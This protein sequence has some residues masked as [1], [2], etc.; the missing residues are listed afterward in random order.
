MGYGME[1]VAQ[2][3]TLMPPADDPDAPPPLTDAERDERERLM[4][5]GFV[6]WNKRDFLNFIRGCDMRARLPHPQGL[7]NHLWTD[8]CPI[9]WC[10]LS[11]INGWHALLHTTAKSSRVSHPSVHQHPC[12]FSSVVRRSSFRLLSHVDG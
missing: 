4:T 6:S 3:N 11:H 5:E 12:T 10:T 7:Q 2:G 1:W 9:P 8:A